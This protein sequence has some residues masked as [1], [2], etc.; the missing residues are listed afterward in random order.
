MPALPWDAPAGLEDFDG[1]TGGGTKG[2]GDD[3]DGGSPFLGIVVVI[4][5]EAVVL[6]ALLCCMLRVKGSQDRRRSS[7]HD[8]MMA[9][10]R[11]GQPV[12]YRRSAGGQGMTYHFIV[13]VSFA[14]FAGCAPAPPPPRAPRRA[15]APLTPASQLRA[16]RWACL[17]VL[18]A[19]T[20]AAMV[21]NLEGSNNDTVPGSDS[22]GQTPT[23]QF[24]AEF[25]HAAA[26]DLWF[27]LIFRVMHNVV[28][29]C[30]VPRHRVYIS[31]GC[32]ATS[33]LL[34]GVGIHM[35]NG[36]N[37][38]WV[39]AAYMLGG[40]AMGMFETNLLNSTLDLGH[41][42]KT[43]SILG[44]PGEPAQPSPRYSPHRAAL[45]PPGPGARSRLCLDVRDRLPRPGSAD[46]RTR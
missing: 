23:E 28:F 10:Y 11:Q 16:R 37:I 27:N 25:K 17:R 14:M 4:V 7:L 43:W 24:E 5:L 21:Q 46:Q 12:N 31:L 45:T 8:N 44:M 41:G 3:D 40:V 36:V 19:D 29:A 39:Y 26:F 6:A 15:P 34:I 18:Q 2:G 33:M 9:D 13:T 42:T 35:L 22:H 1:S 38:A 32:M 30:F 20:M